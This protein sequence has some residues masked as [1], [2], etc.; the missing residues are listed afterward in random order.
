MKTELNKLNVGDLFMYDRQIWQKLNAQNF[1]YCKG[2]CKEGF[3]NLICPYNNFRFE[4]HFSR[5]QVLQEYEYMLDDIT[6]DVADTNGV[7]VKDISLYT[8]IDYQKLPK[9]TPASSYYFIL[10]NNLL[11]DDKDIYLLGSGEHS[12]NPRGM[13]FMKIIPCAYFKPNLTVTLEEEK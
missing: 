10:L 13:L 6:N 1:C 5:E 4:A 9:D 3:Q 2:L 12:E 11:N 7:F 8:D